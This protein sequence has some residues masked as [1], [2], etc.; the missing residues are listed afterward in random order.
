MKRLAL[1]L[2][3]VLLIGCGSA[4]DCV[5]REYVACTD[6]VAYWMDSCDNVGEVKE[7]C[8][9]GCRTD[10]T[11]CRPCT[12]EPH[13][14]TGCH[15]GDVWWFDSCGEL[16]ELIIRCQNGCQDGACIGCDPDCAGKDCGPDGCG[17]SCGD[18]LGGSVCE[19]FACVC[20]PQASTGCHQGD[21]WWFD[22]CGNPE[23][24]Y[25][26]CEH[27]CQGGS[28][29]PC[30]GDCTGRDCGDDGCGGSCGDCDPGMT[31]DPDGQCVQACD[32]PA[33]TADQTLDVDLETYFLS[34]VV[35]LD[36]GALPDDPMGYR[37]ADIA[38]VEVKTGDRLDISLNAS[39]PATFNVELYAGTYRIL[40][41]SDDTDQTVLPRQETIAARE[42]LLESNQTLNIDLQPVTVSGTVTLNGG[43]MPDEPSGYRRGDVVFISRRTGYRM[44]V[45]MGASGP[46]AYSALVYRDSY[47]ILVDSDDTDQAVLPV[48]EMRARERMEILTSSNLDID[49]QTA[50][51]TGTVTRNGAALLDEPNL[52]R[53]GEIFFQR[54]D[55]SDRIDYSVGAEG[56][57][58]Y[59]AYL[60]AGAYAIGFDSDDTDQVVLPQQ[61]LVLI[62]QHSFPGDGWFDLD[63]D[64]VTA[65]GLVTLN[66]GVLPDDP[67]LYRRGDVS[68]SRGGERLDVGIGGSGPGA[69]NVELYAGEYHIG[70]DSDDTD[71]A[72]LPQQEIMMLR[73]FDLTASRTVNLDLK[74]IT[75]TGAVTL[76][77]AQMPDDPM[78][79]RRG[80]VRFRRLDTGYFLDIP[81]DAAGPA[82]YMTSLYAGKYNLEFDSNDTDQTVLPDLEI[83]VRG[84]L[85]IQTNSTLDFDLQAYTVSGTVTKN[86][87][88]MPDDPSGYRRGDMRF[89]YKLTGSI[90]DA[91]FGAAG[92]AVYSA[93]LY[94]GGYDLRVDSN[95]TDQT[96][97]PDLEMPLMKGC[98]TADTGCTTPADDLTGSW[99]VLFD[100]WT[101][102]MTMDLI[103]SGDTLSGYASVWWGSG[104]ISGTRNG[105]SVEF[106]VA[107]S[108]A[109]DYLGEVING[110]TMFGTGDSSASSTGWVA[111]RTQ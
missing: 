26:D 105:N 51:I 109:T 63:L 28:C 69:F 20:V 104:P 48:L 99:V 64:V 40:I 12:C 3:V 60:Y 81:V 57:G 6:G 103:Q 79:Y 53:R 23:S 100:Y 41:D 4:K 43:L 27:G 65:S 62:E 75:M 88:P 39:G 50:Q 111:F 106:H 15:E 108:T 8:Q 44:D 77:G 21:V 101:G 42:F 49:V 7:Q 92:A 31:C 70:F 16:D 97:L 29:G 24:L 78:G 52:Y 86:G 9:C 85:D 95:D 58:T 89:V 37:R 32:L 17:G 102:T 2:P 45:S 107:G 82:T 54:L 90:F 1:F 80:D 94:A 110:C 96:V 68:F 18:C 72:V 34:G 76:N 61:D 87:V 30:V 93:Y 14:T 22:S 38:F 98:I 46:A 91:G 36:G 25:E 11:D 47:D 10:G 56:D 19:N 55:T 33:V 73:G 74:V 71:Q 5:P 84:G 83:F 67:N 13:D 66:G 35:T 59:S